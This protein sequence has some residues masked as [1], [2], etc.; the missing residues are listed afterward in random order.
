MYLD[1]IV[2]YGRTLKE[3]KKILSI[4]LSRLTKAG[5]KINPKKC[6][7]L[8]EQVVVLG[9]VVSREGVSTDPEKIRVI[10]DPE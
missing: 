3:N 10:K 6:K 7:V 9:H 4:V 1:D 8:G 2:V 5:L